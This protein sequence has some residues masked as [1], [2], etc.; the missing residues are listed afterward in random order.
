MLGNYSKITLRNMKR[1]KGYSFIN[2][3]GTNK[4][5][6]VL[7]A[8]LPDQNQTAKKKTWC[9]RKRCRH[10]CP[11]GKLILRPE[12]RKH[13]HDR[14]NTREDPCVDKF[15]PFCDKC[16]HIPPTKSK[17]AFAEDTE[18]QKSIR[19]DILRFITEDHPEKQ[20]GYSKD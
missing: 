14:N 15:L 20:H 2:I 11:P 10:I 9:D 5:L 13:P 12:E 3:A 7:P 8:F 17:Q 4:R 18:D 1:Q 16:R 6:P 19:G